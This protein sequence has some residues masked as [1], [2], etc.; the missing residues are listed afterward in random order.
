V[1]RAAVAADAEA[2]DCAGLVEASGGRV[3]V[4]PGDPRLVKVTTAADLAQVASW[5]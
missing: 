2:S 5:L 4:V 1:L 3:K